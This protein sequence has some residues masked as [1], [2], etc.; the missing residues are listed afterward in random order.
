MRAVAAGEPTALGQVQQLDS[1][2]LTGPAVSD[3]GTYAP[4]V[5]ARLYERL[6]E[7]QRALDALRRRGYLSGWPRYLAT[8]RREE[9]R[10]ALAVG[11]SAGAVAVYR[12][13]LALR[14]DAEPVAASADLVVRRVLSDLTRR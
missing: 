2:M 9:G 10:L 14:A 6:G 5:V 3:A 8:A 1:L 13:Y 4:L 12:Q 7:P 11:D